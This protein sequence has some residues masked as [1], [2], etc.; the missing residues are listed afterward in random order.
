MDLPDGYKAF[1]KT[2]P[3]LLEHFKPVIE[4]WNN[5]V[6]IKDIKIDESTKDTWKAKKFSLKEIIDLNYNL[7]QCSFPIKENII[8]TPKET[9][10]NF[11]SLRERLESELDLKL[12]EIVD[13]IGEK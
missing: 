12:Q 5:R 3:V 7:D 10:D 6:E 2:K 13:I 11:I 4:W 9:M 8:L 1:S